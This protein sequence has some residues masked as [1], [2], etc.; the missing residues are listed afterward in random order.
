ML[1][2]GGI[3]AK[4]RAHFTESCAVLHLPCGRSLYLELGGF[5]P[6]ELKPGGPLSCASG[7]LVGLARPQRSGFA[8]RVDGTAARLAAKGEARKPC[9]QELEPIGTAVGKNVGEAIGLCWPAVD[10]LTP[11]ARTLVDYALTCSSGT[12]GGGEG[13][14]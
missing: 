8:H 3:I 13:G 9:L 14:G 1:D 6:E 2:S 7:P 11:E 10:N 12:M 4:G 5:L